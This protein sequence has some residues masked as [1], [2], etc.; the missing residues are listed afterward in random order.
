[1]S[2]IAHNLTYNNYSDVDLMIKIYVNCFDILF[3][4]TVTYVMML[5]CDIILIIIG[6]C[7]K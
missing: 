2:L 6:N 3:L 5:R 1:M 4:D 7:L